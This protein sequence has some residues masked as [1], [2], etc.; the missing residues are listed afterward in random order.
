[1]DF[2]DHESIDF[3]NHKVIQMEAWHD[4]H[5]HV[6]CKECWVEP[7]VMLLLSE[8][9]DRELEYRLQD[10]LQVSLLSNTPLETYFVYMWRVFPQSFHAPLVGDGELGTILSD[11]TYAVYLV[12]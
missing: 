10:K 8:Q 12:K 11:T 7:S 5:V 9:Q 1:M 3:R 4:V 2:V 6:P